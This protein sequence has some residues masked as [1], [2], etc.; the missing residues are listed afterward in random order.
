ML[1]EETREKAARDTQAT[2]KELH[3]P[4]GRG[5]F[6]YALPR[7]RQVLDHKSS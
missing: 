1:R 7:T 6:P 2:L 3:D 4:V 5:S